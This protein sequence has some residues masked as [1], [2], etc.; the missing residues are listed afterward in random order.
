LRIRDVALVLEKNL[1]EDGDEGEGD[2]VKHGGSA[3]YEL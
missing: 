2:D 1:S 3:Y